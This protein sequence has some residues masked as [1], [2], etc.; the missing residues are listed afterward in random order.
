M[1]A[2]NDSMQ[3]VQ[4]E[5]ATLRRYLA[6]DEDTPMEEIFKMIL[7]FVQVRGL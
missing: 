5:L 1:A 3:R 6:F 4:L 7:Q 2:L